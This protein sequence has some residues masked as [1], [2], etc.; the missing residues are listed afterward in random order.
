MAVIGVGIDVVDHDRAQKL[1][2]RHGTRALNRFLL[3]GE[4][5]YVTSRGDPTRHF[6][7]RVA[8]KEAVYKAFQSLAGAEAIR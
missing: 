5:R 8:A 2:L 4:R 7:V 3:P 6:A 1:L